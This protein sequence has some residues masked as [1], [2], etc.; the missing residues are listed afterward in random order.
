M[1]LNLKKIGI[2]AVLAVSVLPLL[3]GAQLADKPLENIT[4]IKQIMDIINDVI[5]YIF[6]FLIIMATAMVLYAAYLYLTAGGSEENIG[7]AKNA[8]IYAAVGVAVALLSRAVAF[9]VGSIV[10]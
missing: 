5:N 10:K 7:K 8:I 4:T 6:A 3:A 9:I 2:V 1:K